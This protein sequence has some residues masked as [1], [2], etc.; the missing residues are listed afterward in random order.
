MR[1]AVRG[2]LFLVLA[3]SAP[4]I[5]FGSTPDWLRAAARQPAGKYA[6]DV[7]GVVL[8]S[9]QE[10]VVSD[11]GDFT[12]HHRVAFRILRPEGRSLAAMVLPFDG[13]TKINYLHAWSLTPQG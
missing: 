6:D 5:G 13:E 10:T 1:K 2:I 7:N 11:N 4:V 9:E 8:L 12:D 3:L